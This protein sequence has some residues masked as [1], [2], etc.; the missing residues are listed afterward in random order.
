MKTIAI[1]D[2]KMEAT[3]VKIKMDNLFKNKIILMGMGK[4]FNNPYNKKIDLR[5]KKYIN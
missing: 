4:V 5:H 2:L 3:N 1:L